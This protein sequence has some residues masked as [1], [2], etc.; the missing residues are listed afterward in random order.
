MCECTTCH[1]NDGSD[2]KC[3]PKAEPCVTCLRRSQAK[4]G[5]TFAEKVGEE[6][7]SK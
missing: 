7:L 3:H 6:P 1:C 2:A 5:T 4:P